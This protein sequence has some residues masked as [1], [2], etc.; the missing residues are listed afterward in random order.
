MSYYKHGDWNAVCDSCGFE[1]K[2]SELRE[3][4][5]GFMV[6][7]EDWEPRHESDFFRVRPDDSSVPWS[8]PEPTD[9]TTGTDVSGNSLHPAVNT[10]T[11]TSIPDGT[12]DGSL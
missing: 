12:N 1:F 9:N 5:D 4:W 11:Q 7:K 2:A 3:R 6:C 8:R 10:D